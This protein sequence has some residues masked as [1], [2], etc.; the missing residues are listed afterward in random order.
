[1]DDSADPE[2]F[3]LNVLSSEDD[4][5]IQNRITNG[6]YL[7]STLEA[8]MQVLIECFDGE[9]FGGMLITQRTV[10]TARTGV[11]RCALAYTVYAGLVDSDPSPAANHTWLYSQKPNQASFYIYPDS[12][13]FGVLGFRNAFPT[14]DYCRPGCLYTALDELGKVATVT[15]FGS[16]WGIVSNFPPWLAK[17][18]LR[19]AELPEYSG[20]M[21][22][23]DETSTSIP[24]R[25]AC[26]GDHGGPVFTT[27]S[28]GTHILV[29]ITLKYN[30]TNCGGL[31]YGS[32]LSPDQ[33]SYRNT[34]AV[35]ISAYYSSIRGLMSPSDIRGYDLCPL[36]SSLST[37]AVSA[38]A[39][40]GSFGPSTPAT[41]YSGW[42]AP[43]SPVM[44]Q[45]GLL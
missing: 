9:L 14:G 7:D 34:E 23:K 24:Y 15:G 19:I 36:P 13:D 43:I 5:R 28:N 1:M 27:D 39:S 18:E 33:D 25:A 22:L 21:V 42:V 38:V 44:M 31:Y 35:R 10:L 32:A 41:T 6:I 17:I 2:S 8:P 11:I 26:I 16:I 12:Y 45:N 3:K 30:G 37:E 4:K 40:S 20:R 29:G